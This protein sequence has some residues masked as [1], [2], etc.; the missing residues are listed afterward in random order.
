M[1]IS[2]ELSNGGGRCSEALEV[3]PNHGEE[4]KA[5]V[6]WLS[7]HFQH[8][9]CSSKANEWKKEGRGIVSFAL[10]K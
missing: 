8:L 5:D 1:M 3:V 9:D 6:G 7:D 2:S 4:A 10:M